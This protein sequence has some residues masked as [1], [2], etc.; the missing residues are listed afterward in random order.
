MPFKKGESGNIHGRPKGSKG[1]RTLIGADKASIALD[2]IGGFDK[3][4][5]IVKIMI[6][7]G[8]LKD[9]ASII[10]KL[11]EFAHP[12]LKAV[13]L[14]AN[15]EDTRKHRTPAEIQADLDKFNDD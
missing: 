13:D 4:G 11:A 3:V 2:A 8:E 7:N 12:K 10:L 5:N 15:I 6:E 14:T 1:K 9:A